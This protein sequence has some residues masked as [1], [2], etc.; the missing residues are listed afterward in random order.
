M[1]PTRPFQRKLRRAEID[2][3]DD[4]DRR[5]RREGERDLEGVVLQGLD[6]RG[7]EPEL[8]EARVEGALFLGCTFAGRADECS[9]VERGAVVFP[10]L[11]GL[12][13]EP[14]RNALYTVDE[15]MEGELEG[16]YTATRDFRI[17]AHYD[18]ARC[19][20]HGV[21]L[22][23]ALAQRLHD[24]AIDDALEELL[25]TRRGRGVVAL[26]GGHGTRRSDPAFAAVAR[27]SWGLAR[28]GY[29]VATG[30]GPGIMEAG[31]LGAYLSSYRD[32]AVLG[33]AIA[34]L[35]EADRF[36]GDQEEGTPEYLAAIRRYFALGRQVVARFG[37]GGCPETAARLGREGEAAGE[38][39]AIPTWFY[40][41]EPSN[42]WSTH[43][44]KYFSNSLREDGLLAI[45][46]AGVVYAPGSAGT[47]QEVFMDLAQNHYATFELRSPMVFLGEAS[48]RG[49]VELVRAFVRDKGMDPVYGDLIHITD[50]PLDALD[51]IVSHP[52][53]PRAPRTPLYDLVSE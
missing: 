34:A 19:D 7:F 24:H 13:Y 16:G 12:P 50:D 38:S 52:P 11:T 2:R 45:A 41:H 23:E 47:L 31:N 17:Y 20:P 28:E 42:L 36:D 29:F 51:F 18:R 25:Y 40:G 8:N 39:L 3:L 21:P 1:R 22:V 53:R 15:L 14:Y 5:L 26:M 43:V 4:L 46:T 27:L 6:L 10:R 9:L 32:P 30:G 33:E 37:P 44:A 35:S 49:L 48:W